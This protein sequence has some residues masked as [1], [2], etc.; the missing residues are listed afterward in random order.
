MIK[1]AQ[2]W[3]ASGNVYTWDL[4]SVPRSSDLVEL[5]RRHI[6]LSVGT[7]V[8]T[9]YT[10]ICPSMSALSALFPIWSTFPGCPSPLPLTLLPPL[11]DFLSP[12][13]PAFFF[14]GLRLLSISLL[15]HCLVPVFLYRW[16]QQCLDSAS[17]TASFAFH[18]CPDCTYSPA[19]LTFGSLASFSVIM[20]R[21]FPALNFS[22]TYVNGRR[23]LVVL[24]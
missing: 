11:P 14:L 10:S 15:I 24:L 17:T 20:S 5:A 16:F 4:L 23:S 9:L 3:L 6:L 1:Y 18:F 2:G 19:S 22:T 21:A 13:G 8:G 12:A 7:A